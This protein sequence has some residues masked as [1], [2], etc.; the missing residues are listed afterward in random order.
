MSP[1]PPGLFFLLLG[2]IAWRLFASGLP[3]GRNCENSESRSVWFL[4]SVDTCS[5]TSLIVFCSFW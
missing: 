2:F 3:S 5:Y 1:R 4:K